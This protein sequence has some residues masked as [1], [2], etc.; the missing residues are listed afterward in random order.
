M[1]P[2]GS[3]SVR[4]NLPL[5]RGAGFRVGR[6]LQPDDGIRVGCAFG[7]S[8]VRHQIEFPVQIDACNGQAVGTEDL[9]VNHPKGP[10]LL[11]RTVRALEPENQLVGAQEVQISV[12]IDVH[13]AAVDAGS[14]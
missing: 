7:S 8:R 10:V 12:P 6:N 11:E 1:G 2:A 3:I 13:E 4:K 5:P 14:S 9:L